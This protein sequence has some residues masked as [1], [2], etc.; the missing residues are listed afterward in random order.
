[1][2]EPSAGRYTALVEEHFLHPRNVGPMDDATTVGDATNPVCGDRLRLYLRVRDGCIEDARFLAEGCPAAIA[3]SS[4]TTVLLQG[5]TL[6]EA[7]ALTDADVE[8][9][10]GGLP[11]GKRHCSVLA[12]EAIADALDRLDAGGAT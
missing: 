1:M 8:D 9:A 3:A 4:V 6:D 11:P 10:L 5:R 7:R 12:E 2:S